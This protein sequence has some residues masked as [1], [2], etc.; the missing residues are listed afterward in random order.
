MEPIR[1]RTKKIRKQITNFKNLINI[2]ET[3]R[4][5]QKVTEL[6]K[7]V[8]PVLFSPNDYGKLKETLKDGKVIPIY[9][10]YRHL[11]E[12]NIGSNLLESSKEYQI[13]KGK[14]LVNSLNTI[15]QVI[16]RAGANN[17]EPSK[18]L[19]W[20]SK[21]REIHG[22]GKEDIADLL[23]ISHKIY[24]KGTSKDD[25]KQRLYSIES[26]IAKINQRN[27]EFLKS[28]KAKENL[29]LNYLPRT[30]AVA[31]RNY[32]TKRTK[33]PKIDYFKKHESNFINA[34][35][36]GGGA[37]D[38]V[39][40]FNALVAVH[41]TDYL[42]K[43]GIIKPLGRYSDYQPRE[44]THF[45]LNGIASPF[46]LNGSQNKQ[47]AV[48]V[49]VEKIRH[50]L[51]TLTFE[52]S[53]GHGT[54]KL[55]V[56]TKIFI[57]REKALENR[58]TDKQ[59]LGNAEINILNLKDSKILKV[60]RGYNSINDRFDYEN[61]SLFHR[62]LYHKLT[63]MNYPV[64]IRSGFI[65]REYYGYNKNRNWIDSKLRNSIITKFKGTKG[66]E[67]K[68]RGLTGFYAGIQ[69]P[70]NMHKLIEQIKEKKI[71]LETLQL[72]RNAEIY[73]TDV[74][75]KS[76]DSKK[77]QIESIQNKINNGE[78]DEANN[79]KELKRQL[80]VLN[81]MLKTRELAMQVNE[82]VGNKGIAGLMKSDQYLNRLKHI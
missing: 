17:Y 2:K 62:A 9:L 33:I 75:L 59:M 64:I 30:M 58:V 16:R 47:I 10:K 34:F 24:A 78:S 32:Q 31:L 76:I 66:L 71:T 72:F 79:R 7:E 69:E 18:L 73:N 44:T 21:M 50:W 6:K 51:T 57:T 63:E 60:P 43:N 65:D 25:L 46:M 49:P 67:T 55:P 15:N 54:L 38:K 77:R 56:G 53:Y 35:N 29:N 82:L 12:N 37:N 4:T 41:L 74:Y 81:T 39:L 1:F 36:N 27:E 8:G 80:E 45:A 3:I 68:R 42:P 20:T 23:A 40:D 13:L 52:N 70:E 28:S 26:D 22:N 11:F 19:D 5:N 48:V 14:Q 61:L